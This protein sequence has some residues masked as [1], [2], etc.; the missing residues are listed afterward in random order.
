M[1]RLVMPLFFLN[2]L[3]K[4]PKLSWY[5]FYWLVIVFRKIQLPAIALKL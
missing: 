5:F 3:E 1:S 2:C 4:V